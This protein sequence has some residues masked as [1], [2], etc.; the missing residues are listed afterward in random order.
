LR[1]IDVL[2][3]WWWRRTAGVIEL[4]S[5]ARTAMVSG[6]MLTLLLRSHRRARQ[7]VVRWIHVLLHLSSFEI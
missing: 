1:V 3:W 4:E 5:A 7:W 6:V 2:A